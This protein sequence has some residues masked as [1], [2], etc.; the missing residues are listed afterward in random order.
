MKK[1]SIYIIL[2]LSLLVSACELSLTP[3]DG[4]TKEQ[5]SEYPEGAGYATNGNYAMIKDIL[6]Y[7]GVEDLRNTYV[8]HYFQLAEFPG[9]NISLSGSTTDHLFYACTYR[10][11]ATMMNTTYFWFSGYKIING[12]CQIIESVEEGTSADLDQ[13]IGENYFLRAMA[14]FDLVRIFATPFTQGSDNP[15]IIVRTSSEGQG[16]PRNTVGEVYH[17]IIEDLL[18]GS[19]LMNTPRGNSFASKEAAWALLSRVYLYMEENQLAVDYASMV[20]ESGRFQLESSGA[21]PDYFKNALISSETILCVEHTLQDDKVSGA[22]GSMYLSDQGLGWGEIYASLPLRN[23][24]NKNPEDKRLTFIKPEYKADPD[25]NILTDAQDKPIVAERNGYPKYYMTKFSYQDG[26]VTLSS[27]VLL[28]LAE[29]Y[30][31]RAEAYAKLG[32]DAQAIDD[33]NTIRS[34]ADIPDEALFST[35]NLLGYTSVLDIVLDERRLELF[36]EGH[37]TFDIFRNNMIMNRSYP[38]VH[39]PE[40]ETSQFI[41][42]S[43]PRIIY[44]IP[45][46]EILANPEMIQNK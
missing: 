2:T 38:G 29:V 23:L 33:V 12:A 20:I 41:D 42:P 27:P 17:Q 39:L 45:Q 13:L 1:L 15:G 28:R 30:L 25:G 5:L 7:K 6:E 46:D 3:H 9:D 14:H 10:H 16:G 40:G 24:L 19:E 37:R 43:D 4:M 44:F 32:D 21:Y 35:S 36:T 31:N 22:I 11:F 18:K 8:R 26:M 34:R